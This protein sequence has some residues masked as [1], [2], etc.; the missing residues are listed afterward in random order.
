MALAP[1][2]AYNSSKMSGQKGGGS[3]ECGRAWRG[4]GGK[5]KQD[6]HFCRIGDIILTIKDLHQGKIIM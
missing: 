5:D 4:R 1:T 3:K 6:V 2:P